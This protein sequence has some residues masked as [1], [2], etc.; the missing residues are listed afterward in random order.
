M[1]TLQC[2]ALYTG[3]ENNIT[4]STVVGR[5]VVLGLVW[6]LSWPT[7]TSAAEDWFYVVQP[8]D[9]LW[10]LSA[11]LLKDLNYYKKF[12]RYNNITEPKPLQ[13]GTQLRVPMAWLKTEPAKVKV[14]HSRGDSQVFRRAGQQAKRLK[15]G[16]ILGLGDRVRTGPDSN[17][18]L[19]FA[20]GSLLVLQA[21]TEVV[22]DA[23]AIS[24]SGIMV[25]TRVRLNHGRGEAE[26][27]STRDPPPNFEI[28]TPESVTSVRGTKFRVETDSI[29]H[30]TISEVIEGIVEVVASGVSRVVTA[31]YSIVAEAGKPLKEPRA[32]L[33]RPDL[34]NLS[35]RIESLPTTF[36]WPPVE[37]AKTYRIQIATDEAL[38]ALIIDSVL[39]MPEYTL[40]SLPNGRYAL[41]VRALDK[42]GIEGLNTDLIINVDVPPATPVVKAPKDEKS[43]EES[44]PVFHWESVNG[45]SGYRLQVARDW[46]FKDIILD[47]H[48][49]ATDHYRLPKSHPGLPPSTYYSRVAS[50]DESGK[51][52]PF[53]T[54]QITIVRLTS[55]VDRPTV[56]Q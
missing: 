16:D 33:T 46:A 5:L 54:P 35:T 2:K 31:G 19:E 9:N 48:V 30:I 20:D 27:P 23:L 8:G 50:I 11:N 47:V 41:R 28:I 56:S 55:V 40:S 17:V 43:T 51:V 37:G 10:F 52:S 49:D 29:R 13:P 38:T 4:R 22:L 12:L 18:S 34:S 45:A 53:S 24:A 36:S 1:Y 3:L 6:I 7:A 44:R 14:V 15:K 26:V 32:L 25:E 39:R 42:L 21:E